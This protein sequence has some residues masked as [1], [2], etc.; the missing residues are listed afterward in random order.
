GGWRGIA[1]AVLRRACPHDMD[2]DDRRR[3]TPGTDAQRIRPISARRTAV[4]CVRPVSG[5]VRGLLPEK[6]RLPMP[7]HSGRCDLFSHL[8]LRGQRR[9]CRASARAP[10][11]QFHPRGRG[12]LKQVRR[13]VRLSRRVNRTAIGKTSEQ[14]G[15]IERGWIIRACLRILP[16]FLH[17]GLSRLAQAQDVPLALIAQLQP[18]QTLLPG[19]KAALAVA[20]A[21]QL[22]HP[23]ARAGYVKKLKLRHLPL[24]LTKLH[25][26]FSFKEN[27][28]YR[29]AFTYHPVFLP[30]I[31][32]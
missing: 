6:S 1:W 3:R 23:D 31:P 27:T 19:A 18:V 26:D 7:K 5:L 2:V 28:T 14:V 15:L 16:R 29:H 9:N 32:P 10:A 20:L 21:V 17:A 22:T 4:D 30:R 11:S 13:V 24:R 25:V 8:P 12:H